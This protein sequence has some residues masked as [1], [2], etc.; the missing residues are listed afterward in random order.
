MTLTH[1]LTPFQ[2]KSGLNNFLLPPLLSIVFVQKCSVV[3]RRGWSRKAYIFARQLESLGTSLWN[4]LK[5]EVGQLSL[6]DF[7]S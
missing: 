3:F 6:C 5:N 1:S 7:R 4:T 2:I